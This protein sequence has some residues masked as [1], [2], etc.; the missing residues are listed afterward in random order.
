[1]DICKTRTKLKPKGTKESFIDEKKHTHSYER[2]I[3]VVELLFEHD[4]NNE[5]IY[6]RRRYNRLEAIYGI[7]D[8]D[9]K[10]TEEDYIRN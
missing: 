8:H 5:I 9:D 3:Y 1:M 7:I 10:Y 2:R 6:F 4:E